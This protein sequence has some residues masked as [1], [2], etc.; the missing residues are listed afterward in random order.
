MTGGGEINGWEGGPAGPGP[1]LGEGSR[2][3]AACGALGSYDRE[4]VL[5]TAALLAP[6]MRIAHEG[7]GAI[8]LLDRE[9]RRWREDHGDAHGFAWPA[10]AAGNDD[11]HDWKGAAR[12]WN[13]A[14][15]AIAEGEVFLHT[16]VSGSSPLYLQRERGASYFATAIDPLALA[17]PDLLSVDWQGW[18]SSFTLGLP[19][20]TRTPFEEIEYVGPWRTVT[21]SPARGGRVSAHR[22]PWSEIEPSLSALEGAEAIAEALRDVFSRLSGRDLIVPL[23]AGRDSRLLGWLA[24][25]CDA[26]SARAFTVYEDTG[27]RAAIE[28]AAAAAD[29]VGLAH[30]RLEPTADHFWQD[31]RRHALA[32]DFQQPLAPWLGAPLRRGIA[33]LPGVAIDGYGG[34]ALFEPTARSVPPEVI[35]EPG[36]RWRALLWQKMRTRS[37]RA[38]FRQQEAAAIGALA[39]P[40]FLSHC[41]PFTD[42]PSR[43]ALAFYTSRTVRAIA[44]RPAANLGCVCEVVCPIIDARVAEALLAVR[45][46]DKNDKRLYAAVFDALGADVAAIPFSSEGAGA[47]FEEVPRRRIS[48]PALAGYHQIVG[49]GPL[50][51]HLSGRLRGWL[52]GEQAVPPGGRQAMNGLEKPVAFHLWLQCY[53]DRL[54]PFS[55]AEALGT[56]KRGRR[57]RD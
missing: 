10:P 47:T 14:G 38:A 39:R 16:S 52:K 24:S 32:T 51:H 11:P 29:S 5:A 20:G 4:R 33:G 43:A 8:V 48:P 40:Q 50:R 27:T 44:L 18:A 55:I 3:P 13:S 19:I 34:N 37:L 23:S 30:T 35:S 9:P 31:S 6:E 53:G 42:H 45:P 36:S 22:W 1:L 49:G 17:G 21:H 2:M 25:R 28:M 12:Q 46:E 41:D 57:Q 15:F 26:D 56:P 54:R 7:D